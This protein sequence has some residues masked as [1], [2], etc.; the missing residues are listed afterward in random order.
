M[1]VSVVPNKGQ[2]FLSGCL[3]GLHGQ[4]DHHVFHYDECP[5][6][7]RISSHDMQ[8]DLEA[9]YRILLTVLIVVEERMQASRP[10]ISPTMVLSKKDQLLRCLRYVFNF[11]LAE[12]P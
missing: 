12:T 6:K 8:K 1:Q 3:H 5:G 2:T 7:A 9:F 11:P 4:I 10:A